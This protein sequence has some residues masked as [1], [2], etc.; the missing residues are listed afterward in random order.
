M[1]KPLL[2]W[3]QVPP[4]PTPPEGSSD[5]VIV[6][7]A[8]RNYWRWRMFLWAS[9]G[10]AMICGFSSGARGNFL[11]MP[12][13]MIMIQMFRFKAK[14]MFRDVQPT[15]VYALAR[16]FRALLERQTGLAGDFEIF[17]DCTAMAKKF[18]ERK[19]DV[20]VLHGYEFAWIRGKNPDL[21]P[22]T[23][24]QPQGGINQAF[25]VVHAEG[26]AKKPS[27][28]EGETL[29]IPRGSKGHIFVYLDKLRA[30]LPQTALKTVPKTGMTPEEALNAVSEGEHAAA[31]VDEKGLHQ[32]TDTGAIL[33]CNPDGTDFE[34]FATG[35]RNPQDARSCPARYGA[36]A[37]QQWSAGCS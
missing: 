13:V 6:F 18:G 33:R 26:K 24:A 2:R 7:R 11:F 27:D 4:E 29:L 36:A 32:V 34:V 22:L 8:G 17:P 16:P 15:I 35:V 31:I 25:I 20:G 28:L 9:L 10:L 30:A 37:D 23:I 21:E 1:V 19:I 3:L 5:S 14:G 12:M